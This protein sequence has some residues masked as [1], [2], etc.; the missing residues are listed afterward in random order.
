MLAMLVGATCTSHET[1][2]SC[3]SH[4]A[5]QLA[6]SLSISESLHRPFLS[7]SYVRKIPI[8]IKKNVRG[9]EILQK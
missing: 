4:Q 3:R 6:A 5:P 8:E 2:N 1:H 7:R 9:F